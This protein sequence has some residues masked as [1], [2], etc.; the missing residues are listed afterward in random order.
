[1]RQ[2]EVLS[3]EVLV[4][5]N[6]KRQMCKA[7]LISARGGYLVSYLNKKGTEVKSE[8]L[9]KSQFKDRLKAQQTVILIVSKYL[10]GEIKEILGYET[11]EAEATKKVKELNK[12]KLVYE[13]YT[14]STEYVNKFQGV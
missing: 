3:E 9:Y 4:D 5:I 8:P 2:V 7:V 10:D 13:T 1:M 11:D 6:G 14:Y 12:A